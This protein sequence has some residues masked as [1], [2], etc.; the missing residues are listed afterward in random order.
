MVFSPLAGLFHRKRKP[1]GGDEC[2]PRPQNAGWKFGTVGAVWIL[3]GFQ[4]KSAVWAHGNS[5][6][7]GMPRQS[8]A[9]VKLH[10]GHVGIHRHGAPALGFPSASGFP[11]TA[12]GQT[13][14]MIVPSALL[15]FSIGQQIAADALRRAK[16]KRRSCHG[17][18]LPRGQALLV[19]GQIRVGIDFQH[20]G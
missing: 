11:K 4:A 2:I 17:T 3:L 20:M 12:R 5:V 14:V 6:F 19:Q 13:V 15:Q 9:D 1:G 18:D 7:A 16:I 10:A 8:V